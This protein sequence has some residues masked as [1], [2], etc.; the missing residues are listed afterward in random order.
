GFDGVGYR[1]ADALEQPLPEVPL[2]SPSPN[3]LGELP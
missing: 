1:L 2:S 3:H